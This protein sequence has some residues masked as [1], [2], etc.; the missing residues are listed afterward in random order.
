MKRPAAGGG[1]AQPLACVTRHPIPLLAKKGQAL[2]KSSGNK[3]TTSA[4]RSS[5]PPHAQDNGS[6]M[7]L[8]AAQTLR[9]SLPPT[10]HPPPPEKSRAASKP[11]FTP[12]TVPA[13][14]NNHAVLPKQ[15][16]ALPCVVVSPLRSQSP[17]R[18]I[19]AP[20]PVH[21]IQTNP[22][23]P[24]ASGIRT[25]LTSRSQ[26]MGRSGRHAPALENPAPPHPES[27]LCRRHAST[28]SSTPCACA[29]C[30]RLLENILRHV[31]S[32]IHTTPLVGSP[33]EYK[34]VVCDVIR[35][36]ILELVLEVLPVPFP[37]LNW[38]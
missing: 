18:T 26:R 31:Q 10:A 12:K 4:K 15:R 25:T 19:R 34:I 36:Q 2:S 28:V 1:S 21:Q 29:V 24:D 6:A 38:H 37:A 13:P 5:P 16:P 27:Q 20:R 11:P 23:K 9:P 14:P 7:Q 32:E 33:S 35:A 30:P 8:Y 22:A 17:S 3:L